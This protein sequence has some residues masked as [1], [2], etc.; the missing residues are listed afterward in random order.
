M[1]LPTL[2]RKLTTLLGAVTAAALLL[3][4]VAYATMDY[5]AIRRAIVEELRAQAEVVGAA[6]GMALVMEDP[7]E[8]G[9]Q[10]SN[11]K[12]S[13]RVLKAALFT[14]QGK[15]YSFFPNSLTASD[16]PPL[17]P[18]KVSSVR[19]QGGLV[20]LYSPNDLGDG[21][22][23]YIYVQGRMDALWPR[24]QTTLKVQGVVLAVVFGLVFLLSVRL[25]NT[26][27][28][29]LLRLASTVQAV[30]EK[31]DYGLR[32]KP[33]SGSVEIYRLGEGFN[34]MIAAVQERDDKLLHHQTH[35]E[36]E[37][38]ERTEDLTRLNLELMGAKNRAEDASRAKSAFLANMSHELRTPLN[39][40]LLYSE[41]L[42][43]EAKDRGLNDLTPDIQ[44]IHGAG[45][46]LLR[47]IDGILDL[48]RIE[49]GQ[50]MVVPNLVDLAELV[51]LV[52]G[53]LD[54]L[55]NRQLNQFCLNVEDDLPPLRT[56]PK[57]LHT[58]LLNLVENA[59]KFTQQG[60]VTVEV[61]MEGDLV[62]VDVRDTG[63]G[64]N[65]EQ[66]ERTFQG[67]TQADESS[68][69]RVGGMGMG[70]NLSQKLV[71]MLGGTI[72]VESEE[73]AGT[74][75]TLRLPLEVR[76]RSTLMTFSPSF[77]PAVTAVDCSKGAAYE[78][79]QA[80]SFKPTETNS[81]SGLA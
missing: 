6:A 54:P 24:V 55:K 52:A 64:M 26:L 27:S 50:S 44:T 25:Q 49:A 57:K 62:R 58:I 38:A 46:H 33:E 59:L 12:A 2:S 74:C 75:F 1:P 36:E 40:V 51:W 15:V 47:L 43:Q 9:I 63:I 66:V 67:F 72:K 3:G 28:Q 34:A 79:T 80:W 41:L 81:V 78:G 35:L 69:R 14:P 8:V 71:V 42:R 45:K 76:S 23:S 73:G 20:D 29:P 61:R 7:V 21:V 37:V 32:V 53:E 60:T 4:G 10:L 65:P 19:F 17:P 11:L 16:F 48:S 5:F 70:L 18:T 77:D 68:T 39:A 22:T 31:Q 56:D 13:R 30:R